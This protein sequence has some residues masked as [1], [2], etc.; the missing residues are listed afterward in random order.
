[1]GK[2]IRMNGF[3]VRVF[4]SLI[5]ALSLTGCGVDMDTYDPAMSQEDILTSSSQRWNRSVLE[6][7]PKDAYTL[8]SVRCMNI[9]P[10]QEFPTRFKD[11]GVGGPG[12]SSLTVHIEGGRGYV[13][14]LFS[15]HPER[16]EI[17][18]PWIYSKEDGWRNDDC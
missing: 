1:M 17:D 2:V 11:F 14:T 5:T 6:G 15:V 4:G 3:T 12:P 16:D 9:I 7:Y 8:L 13:T 18:V 10:A